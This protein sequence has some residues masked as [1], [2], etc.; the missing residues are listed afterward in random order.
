MDIISQSFHVGEFFIGAN[1]TGFLVALAVPA[2]IN[3]YVGPA[4]IDEAFFYHSSGALANI[5]ISYRASPAIPA[6]PAHRGSQAD[7]IAHLDAQGSF[8][9]A[10]AVF[11]GEL[12][13]VGAGLVYHAGNV[14]G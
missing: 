3:I 5:F 14:A 11:G 9:Y 1:F 4:I 10:Q 7:F 6:I 12:D 2:V 8:G 13:I